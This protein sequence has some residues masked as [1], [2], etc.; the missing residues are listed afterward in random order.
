[1]SLISDLIFGI[2]LGVILNIFIQKT[3][4]VIFA[5][6]PYNEKYQRTMTMFFLCSIVGFFMAQTI[7]NTT[8]KLRN[9]I[10]RI[11]FTVA[12][13]LLLFYSVLTNWD[14]MAD[15]TKLTIIGIVLISFHL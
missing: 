8:G 11:G 2:P 7:F 15:E 3:A 1:M 12:S 5:T 6:L 9:R 10:M 14:K 4:E 13:I